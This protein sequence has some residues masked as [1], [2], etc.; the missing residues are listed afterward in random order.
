MIILAD[1]IVNVGTVMIL[2]F[3]ASI[4]CAAVERSVCTYNL[5]VG[6]KM[7]RVKYLHQLD[8]ID[9]LRLLEVARVLAK[10]PYVEYHCKAKETELRIN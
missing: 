9:V 2:A 4:A 10:S 1:A 7:A 6:T 5:T 3:N 8:E